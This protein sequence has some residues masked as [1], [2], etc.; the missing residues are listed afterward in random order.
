MTA[1]TTS[2]AGEQD[3]TLQDETSL[4]RRMLVV[5]DDRFIR[6]L[7]TEVLTDAGYHVDVAEDGAVAWDLLRLVNYDLLITDH[8]MPK[9]TGMELLK[10]LHA[11]RM[12]VPAI[13]VSGTLPTWELSVQPWLQP[14][15]VLLKP[16]TITELLE[17]VT[18]VL[19]ASIMAHE[20]MMQPNRQSP[21]HAH[22]LGH[23]NFKSP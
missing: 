17:V 18:A 5:D 10:K 16:Y 14:A 9:V 23:N 12:T 2:A 13:M 11:A 7:N 8:N 1:N 19:D 20:E 21:S 4:I 22:G 3:S 6:D 15:A